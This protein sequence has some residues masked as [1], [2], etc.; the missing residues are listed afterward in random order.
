MIRYIIFLTV[1]IFSLSCFAENQEEAG[2][3]EQI[4]DHQ[5]WGEPASEN[6]NSES[7][8]DKTAFVFKW[9]G[10]IFD[11]AERRFKRGLKAADE[12]GA[13]YVV[14]ELNTYGGRVDVADR[15]HQLLLGSKATSIVYV[16]TNAASAG[17]LISLSCDSIFM[18][19][20]SQIGAATVVSE[21]GQQAPDKYQ[22]YMRATM[23]STAESQGRDPMIAEAMVDDRVVIAGIIDS[24]RT[25]TFTTQEAIKHGYCEGMFESSKE[26]LEHLQVKEGN[27]TQYQETGMDELMDWLLHP[28]L[29]GALMVIMFAGV[30][31][32]LQT[33]GVGFPL[34]ASATAAI[35]YFAPHYLEGLAQNWEILLFIVGL[36]L[37]AAE[38]FVIPGFGV[39]GVLGISCMVVGLAFSQVSIDIPQFGLPGDGTVTFAFFNVMLSLIVSIVLLFAFGGSILNSAAFDGLSLNTTQKA[40]EGYTI[41]GKDTDLLIGK[42]GE[43]ATDLRISG[44]VQIN[45]IYYDAIT[46]GEYIEKGKSVEVIENRGNYY[47]VR[48]A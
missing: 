3:A 15:I 21:Q 11:A 10:E 48:S 4:Q 41:K 37:L 35:L 8:S 46:R 44:K 19:P 1:F 26:L 43:T 9:D 6:S 17:A 25:L 31:F 27:I 47:V 12:Q 22:S 29:T 23:R 38:V 34:M 14:I 33:P 28:A 7:E 40:D 30:Y 45:G 5:E 13:D 39:A 20:A 2:E 36:L 18:A 24:G 32:E 16:N 42:T